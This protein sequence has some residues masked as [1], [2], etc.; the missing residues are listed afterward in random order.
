MTITGSRD[1]RIDFSHPFYIGNLTIAKRSL[2]K[3]N[4]WLSMIA[5]FFN[6]RLLYLVLIL[7][8][9]VL[10]FGVL[11]W[12]IEKGNQ[13][14]DKNIH[15]LLSSFWWSAV[16]MTT[17]GY[18]D[19]VPLSNAG[20]LLAFV[21]MLCSLII[22]SVFTAS[23][24]SSLTVRKLAEADLSMES[25][26]NEQV[27]TVEQSASEE[28]LERNFFKKVN[29]YPEFIKGLEGLNQEEVDYF[30]YDEPWLRYQLQ[31]NPRFTELELLPVRFNLCLYAM[32]M[33]DNMDDEVEDI[34]S[35][36]IIRIVESRDW[37]A[38]LKEYHL[39]LY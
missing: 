3:V 32:P 39:E 6:P 28:F 26:K 35:E 27:G 34:I 16:T 13:H 25:F 22:I 30:I 29:A 33:T 4:N 11:I 21:W 14:F 17:V 10:L 7:V 19:K 9:M 31:G 15:G 2:S 5:D 23:V 12:L 18:G 20:R 24:T 37:K 36:S 1:D 38:L 8:G